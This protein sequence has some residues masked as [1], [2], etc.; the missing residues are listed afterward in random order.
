MRISHIVNVYE[1]ED[2]DAILAQHVT[3]NSLL[4]AR[5]NLKHPVDIKILACKHVSDPFVIPS[6]VEFTEGLTRYAHDAHKDL[7]A[8]KLLPI[9]RD[10]LSR[11]VGAH[12]SDFYIYSNSD[13]GVY[14]NLY[15][16]LFHRL[17]KYTL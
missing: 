4:K 14:P 15:N 6:G 17:N 3:L 9:L 8:T 10:I 2:P 1:T 16:K 13:I 7:P 5:A 11:G 12:D